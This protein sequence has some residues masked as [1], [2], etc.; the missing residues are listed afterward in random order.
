VYQVGFITRMF[1][2]TFRHSLQ[3]EVAVPK[4]HAIEK[5]GGSESK[6]TDS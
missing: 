2:V 1:Y 6:S 4:G 5:F 3:D